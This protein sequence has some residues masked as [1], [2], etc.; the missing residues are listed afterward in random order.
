MQILRQRDADRRRCPI[1]RVLLTETSAAAYPVNYAI[2][3]IIGTLLEEAGPAASAPPPPRSVNPMLPQ[4]PTGL[5]GAEH[6]APDLSFAEVLPGGSPELVSDAV[7]D[8]MH[9]AFSLPRDAVDG[10]PSDW[11]ILGW[12]ATGHCAYRGAPYASAPC[13]RRV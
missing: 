8:R 12:T 3:E 11:D 1:D 13:V 4:P 6:A 7:W 9:A 5:P 10:T 2:V